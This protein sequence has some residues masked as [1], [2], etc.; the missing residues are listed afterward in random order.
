MIILDEHGQP[1]R[2]QLLR[3]GAA[4]LSGLAIAAPESSPVRGAP[5]EE[6]EIKIRYSDLLPH[7]LKKK[8]GENPL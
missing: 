2:R 4:G 1:T 6:Q 3:A 8:L 5:A 7:E